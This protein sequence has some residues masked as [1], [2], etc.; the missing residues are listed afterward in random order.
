[1][2]LNGKSL[3]KP[4]NGLKSRI[5]IR[6]FY[7]RDERKIPGFWQI[8]TVLHRGAAAFSFALNSSSVPGERIPARRRVTRQ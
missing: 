4:I 6:T 8:D 1:M 7:S 2:K 5:P 3:T